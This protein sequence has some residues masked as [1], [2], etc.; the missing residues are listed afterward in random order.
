VSWYLIKAEIAFSFVENLAEHGSSFF[1]GGVPM[2]QQIGTEDLLVD[3]HFQTRKRQREYSAI[4]TNPHF[5]Q[6]LNKRIG[7]TFL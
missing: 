7:L 4:Y 5:E 6:G 3:E 1:K 2:A